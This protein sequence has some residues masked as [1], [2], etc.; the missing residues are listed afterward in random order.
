M[1]ASVGVRVA[2]VAPGLV[3]TPLWSENPDKMAFVDQTRDE[4][5]TP[6]EVAEATL[7]LIEKDKIGGEKVRGGTVLEVGKGST[8]VVEILHDK[9]PSGPGLGATGRGDSM[10]KLV[11][12]LTGGE[13][14][15]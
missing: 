3:L 6:E 1:E 13:W 9:G 11:E 2:A 7:A 5:V 4:W 12:R 8:R 10:E 14:G 15:S